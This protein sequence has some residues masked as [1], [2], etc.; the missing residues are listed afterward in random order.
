M[1]NDPSTIDHDPDDRLHGAIV[2]FE[3]ARD[4]GRNPDPAAWLD[5]YPD[6]AARLAEYFAD[7]NGLKRLAAPLLP[8][9][10]V[11]SLPRPFGAYELLEEIGRG[12][13][14]V[15]YRAC[16]VP[17]KRT[18]ALKM[19]LAGQLASP[20]EVR[21]F[22]TEAENVARL[23][24]PHIVPIH[25]VGE[26]DGQHY[27]SMKFIEGTNLGQQLK[28][29]TADPRAAAGLVALV[30]RA[31]HHAHQRGILHRDLKPGNILLDA[32]GQP[33]VT[34]FGLAKR[35]AEGAGLTLSGAVVGTPPYMAPEQAAGQNRE[36]TTAADV[37]ALGAILYELMT[38][39]PPFKA[40]TALETLRLVVSEAPV[41]PSCLRAGVPRA[42]ERV[43]LKCLEK[44][45]ERRYRSAAALADDL[46]RWLR[47]EPVR[48]DEEGRL[49]RLWWA[50][51]RHRQKV[52]AAA[53]LVLALAA[54]FLLLPQLASTD[55]GQGAAQNAKGGEHP[56]W[57]LWKIGQELARGKPVTLV[58][59]SGP[60]A[61]WH[62]SRGGDA[63]TLTRAKDQPFALA[64]RAVGQLKLLP[65]PRTDC[66]RFRA[67]VR[68]DEVD[69]EDDLVQSQ[70]GFFRN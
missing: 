8:A 55:T 33:H 49:R 52:V 28:R 41:R 1:T 64:T 37:Y 10:P 24:H 17:L 3:Q 57:A 44:R 66:Y 38:G 2:S 25:E 43:C 60:P 46:E 61:W 58:G 59:T 56:E 30:A 45:P 12:G 36:L 23:D 15:V 50:L 62:W 5:D 27:F 63:T 4:D 6:V 18:V 7:Q 9:A 19:I 21:R 14:G 29:F 48:F 31:V 26:Q 68:H 47:K 65:D 13:M 20:D 39:E 53:V 67:E 34:D 42:L 54:G 40:A 69:E 16:Q 32:Q 11:C 51:E 22:R 35:I 70:W